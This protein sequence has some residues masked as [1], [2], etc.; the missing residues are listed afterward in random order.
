MDLWK[1]L[2]EIK[3][4]CRI[5]DLSHTVSPETPH[6]TGFPDMQDDVF[7]SYKKD[8]FYANEFQMVSQYGTHVDAPCHFIEGG[9][10]VDL[11]S[12]GEMFLPLCVIDISK[13]AASNPDYA[14][15]TEDLKDWEAEYGRIPAG[16]FVALRTDWSKRSDMDNFDDDGNKHYPAWDWT[17]FAYLL[18]AET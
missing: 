2:T 11:I 15:S 16:A 9:R 6:W 1:I 17:R 14:A 12:P 5:V 3:E 4:E 13:K 10:S 8:G 7:F 18:K